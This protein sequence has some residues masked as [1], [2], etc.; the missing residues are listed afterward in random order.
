LDGPDTG[1]SRADLIVSST[2]KWILATHGGGLIGVPQ[3]SA[4]RW[5]VPAGGWFHLRDAFGPDRFEKA[6][7]LPGAAGF[8]V[9]MPNYPAIYAIRAALDYIRGVGVAA[10]DAAARPLTLRVLDEVSKLPVELITPRDPECVAGIVAFRHL[11]SDE[12]QKRL[13]A[14][15]IHIMSHAGR[16]RVA[17]H[18][19][20][21]EDDIGRLLQGLRAALA[22]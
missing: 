3:A 9:G 19:Y 15:D 14:D 20:N 4:E 17:V 13:R 18:G 16:L 6:E 8:A 7:S 21:T 22:G 12:I 10:I 1:L 2:H 11:R 5:N